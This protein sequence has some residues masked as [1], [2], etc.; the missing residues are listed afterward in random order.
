MI[1]IKTPQ[2]RLE[3]D[4]KAKAMKGYCEGKAGF[5]AQIRAL[6]EVMKDGHE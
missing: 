4:S 5:Q 1:L 3:V 2:G 6:K